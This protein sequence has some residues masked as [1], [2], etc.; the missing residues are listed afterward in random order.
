MNRFLL[1]SLAFVAAHIVLVGG[2]VLLSIPV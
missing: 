2:A 1:P